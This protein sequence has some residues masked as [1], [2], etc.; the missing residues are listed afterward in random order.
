MALKRNFQS[1]ETFSMS[2]MTDV[3]FLLLIFFMVTSTIIF[4][5]AI[6]VNLPQSSEQT[7]EKPVTE[8]Y[9]DSDSKYYLVVD[10]NDSVVEA[11]TS[12][13]EISLED[14]KAEL[15]QIHQADSTR[16]VALYADSIVDYGQVV[17]VL[18]MAAR[19]NMHMVLATKA[20]SVKQ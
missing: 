1:L 7:S 8:V 17:N 13:R 9:I 14:L 12:P 20:K 15:A 10:R 2:S 18:D 16:A 4:P 6:D 19:N 11:N 5:A 3:I